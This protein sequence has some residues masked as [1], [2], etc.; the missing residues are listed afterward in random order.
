LILAV[1]IGGT[2]VAAGLVDEL[3]HV[4]SSSRVP[5]N[6]RGTAQAAM[7]C[8][9]QAIRQALPKDGNGVTAIGV[10]S[11]GPLDP[12][13]GVVIDAPNLPCWQN[14]GLLA[15]IQKAYALPARLDNDANAAGLA[16]AVWGAGQGFRYVLYVTIGTGIGTALVLDKQ[17]YY[18]R[19]GAAA[20]GGHMTINHVGAVQCGCGKPGCIEGMASGPAIG[21]AAQAAVAANPERGRELLA[22]AGGDTTKI[23]AEVLLKAARAGDPFAQEELKKIISV[24]GVW[25]GNMIDMLEPDVI[26]FGGGVGA[27][28]APWL[29]DI[30]DEARKWSINR[31]ATEI[32]F[33][34]ARYGA[35]AGLAGSAALW[36]QGTAK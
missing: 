7:D 15:E 17:I 32:P 36:L 5:M 29:R 28:L 35:D 4:L 27:G 19:T 23:T 24:L 3:G 9:H 11:P 30:G 26:V 33:L 1:D 10:S 8:V 31:R 12:H 6:A 34:P 14:F 2:K 20:E 25:I 13:L 22:L 16:E 18:G 21:R